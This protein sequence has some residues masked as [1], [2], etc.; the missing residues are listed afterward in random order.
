MPLPLSTTTMPARM[1]ELQK[2]SVDKK[3]F[4]DV[5]L[6]NMLDTDSDGSRRTLDQPHII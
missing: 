2:T 3:L 6:S 5:D 4:L 1:N